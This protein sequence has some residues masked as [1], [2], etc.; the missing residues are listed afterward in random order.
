MTG[1]DAPKGRTKARCAACG[2]WANATSGVYLQLLYPTE[3]M[4][5]GCGRRTLFCTCSRGVE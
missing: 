3:H 4:C 1:R 2:R 5:Q